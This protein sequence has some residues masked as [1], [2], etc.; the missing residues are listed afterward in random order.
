MN[1]PLVDLKQQ[2]ISIKLEIKEAMQR[3][4]DSCIFVNGLE[5]KKC[6]DTFASLTGSSFGVGTSSGT[7]ALYLALKGFDIGSGDEVIT[8]ANTFAATVEAI[9]Q[10]GADVKFVDIDEKTFNLD[11]TK[12]E[13]C[14][15]KK[16]KAIIPVHLYGQSCNMEDIDK[17][18]KAYGVTVIND[19][20]QAHLLE[21]KEKKIGSMRDC[22]CYSF[23]PGKNLGCYGDGGMVTSNDEDFSC[24]IRMLS[25]HGT[26]T[27]YVHE[28]SGYNYRFDELQAAVLNVKMRYITQWTKQR[29]NLATIYTERLKNV[30]IKTPSLS[31]HLGHVFHLY[32]IRVKRRDDIFVK[33]REKGIDV[34]I[35]YPIPLH[36]QK[37][38]AFLGGKEGDLPVTEMCT[39]DVLSLPLFPEMTGEQVEYVCDTLEEVIE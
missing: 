29:Q 9:V 10:S 13:S 5:V 26:T 22:H 34:G 32:V 21:Y 24:R 12:I 20:A 4:L 31:K 37:A 27:K 3:V 36:L 39:R 17:I 18:A 30:N 25:K 11:V 6:E 23:F 28:V 2:Y 8:V 14:I 1:I 19:S 7:T 15:S 35:H 38:F 16:T 33:M